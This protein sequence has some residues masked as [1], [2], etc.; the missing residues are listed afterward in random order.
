M[1]IS[2]SFKVAIMSACTITLLGCSGSDNPVATATIEWLACDDNAQLDCATL[3][4]PMDYLEP[5][6]GTIGLALRRKAAP[7]ATRKGSLL[8]H[9]GG[10]GAAADGVDDLAN[11]DGYDTPDA[12]LAEYDLVGFDP[13]GSGG[14]APIDCDAFAPAEVNTYPTTDEDIRA[15][16]TAATQFASDCYN[17]YGNFLLNIGSQAA[18]QDM[19]SIRVALGEEKLHFFGVSFG[20]RM[21]SLYLQNYWEQTK[22]LKCK[23]TWKHYWKIAHALILRVIPSS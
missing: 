19:D 10:Q 6:A 4:V 2:P 8:V 17:K 14:S 12:I 5:S 1:P 7:E 22:S 18:V 15:L 9:L 21:G 16:E 13:R 23:R 20:T 11:R 3:E